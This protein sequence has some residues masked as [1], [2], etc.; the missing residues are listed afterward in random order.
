MYCE[1]FSDEPV[2]RSVHLVLKLSLHLQKASI[3]AHGS[4]IHIQL[5]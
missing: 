3:S 1:E 2:L 4:L 5:Q